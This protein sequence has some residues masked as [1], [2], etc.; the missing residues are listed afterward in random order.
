MSCLFES[1]KGRRELIAWHERFKSNIKFPLTEQTI[2]TSFGKTGLLIG[3]PENSPP[4]VLLHEAYTSSS[5]I[6][7]EYQGLLNH[8]RIFSLDIIGQSVMS[9]DTR[10]AVNNNDY[11][12][13]VVEI[14]DTLNLPEAS[15]LGVSWGGFV[16]LRTAS[17]AS[18]RI[19][20][21]IL[22]TPAGIIHGNAMLGL[23]KIG[24]PMGHFRKKPC[25][26]NLVHCARNVLTSLNDDWL[27]YFGDAILHY[28]P[29]IRAP[30]IVSLNE[31]HNAKF[32]V[33]VIGAENDFSFPGQ[34]LVN[35]SRKIFPGLKVAEVVPNSQ[36]ILPT[37]P[38][39]R[40]NLTKNII[41]FLEMNWSFQ[42]EDPLARPG[43]HSGR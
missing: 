22:I 30:G 19:K 8:Y 21:L 38:D 36:H 16:A 15:I 17:I 10:L 34:I 27:P 42:T 4:L 26:S 40:L 6:L 20:R 24:L 33:M 14:M 9:E 25:F 2:Q 32:P 43:L 1:E 31:F 41:Q 5:H 35:Q 39:F 37:D 23:S 12:K 3:G 29:E 18:H 11:G 28:T 7:K 13:W